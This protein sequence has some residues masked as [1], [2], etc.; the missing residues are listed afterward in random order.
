VSVN[1]QG[2]ALTYTLAPGYALNYSWSLLSG[3]APIQFSSPN[4]AHTNVTVNA[5]GNYTLQ[6]SVNDGI[7]TGSAVMHIFSSSYANGNGQVYLTPAVNGPNAQTRLLTTNGV[8]QVGFAYV[9][10]QFL[11]GTDTVQPPLM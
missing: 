10:E 8:G 6:F 7:T 5:P 1:V 3:P 2:A 9:G 4:A 11:T